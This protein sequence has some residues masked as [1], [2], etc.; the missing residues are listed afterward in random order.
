MILMT[1]ISVRWDFCAAATDSSRE[2]T[3]QRFAA[4][5]VRYFVFDRTIFRN[6]VFYRKIYKVVHGIALQSWDFCTATKDLSCETI[7]QRFAA[8]WIRD[9]VLLLELRFVSTGLCII[10]FIV[11]D[12]FTV[13]TFLE[14]FTIYCQSCC[15]PLELFLIIRDDSYFWARLHNL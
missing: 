12:N 3:R 5:W 11:F 7:R 6:F 2:T 13:N 4:V 15:Y 10:L 8:V 14:G 9:S 1:S